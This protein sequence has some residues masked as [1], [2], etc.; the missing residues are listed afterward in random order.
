MDQISLDLKNGSDVATSWGVFLD[1][2][3]IIRSKK[4]PIK[5]NE[6]D[7]FGL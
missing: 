7:T 5:K 2:N 3:E 4:V 6:M 1:E